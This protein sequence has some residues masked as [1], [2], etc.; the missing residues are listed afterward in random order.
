MKKTL[1][2]IVTLLLLLVS[3]G[4]SDSKKNS[5]VVFNT[6]LIVEG[7]TLNSLLATKSPDLDAISNFTEGLYKVTKDGKL[8]LGQAKK[9][10]VSENGLDWKV[11]LRDDIFWSNGDPVT[12][13]DFKFAWKTALDPKTG[14][15]Y[16]YMLYVI[17][18]GEKINDGK[19]SPDELGVEIIDDKNFIIHLESNTPYFDQLL[20]FDTYYPVN[21][22]FY[23]E[24]GEEYALEPK[25]LLSNGP[26]I[27]TEY[28]QGQK[29]TFVKNEKYW[30]AKNVALD[31]LVIKFIPNDASRLN[32]FKN[33]EIDLTELSS[34]Q[35]DEFKNDNRLHVVKLPVTSY[36]GLNFE[37]PILKN[38]H[39]RKAI[40]L[41][42]N[43]EKL[44]QA[45]SNGITSA[46][47]YTLTPRDAGIQGI[48]KDYIE[49]AIEAGLVLNKYNEAEAKKELELGLKE[50]GLSELPE[51]SVVSGDTSA[52]K[53]IAEY[54]QEQMRQVLGL[55]I[56]VELMTFKE[57][58]ARGVSG[59]Y[60]LILSAW[61]A[62]FL[63]PINFL[64]L[65]FSKSGN[66]TTRLKNEEYDRLINESRVA[67][68]KEERIKILRRLEQIVLE[69]S[70]IIPLSQRI[71]HVLINDKF[72]NVV[73]T[74]FGPTIVTSGIKL[75]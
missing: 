50:L 8:E 42:L 66:N 59:D 18:N 54:F 11:E 56:N 45:T 32:A 3:C 51:L 39:I 14:S 26:F 49:E 9:I 21:E 31:K 15:E 12:S 67:T 6:S 7:D 70:T 61:G 74:T 29:Q 65:L 63:D 22:K 60:Q 48:N 57:R 58:I 25:N 24:Q 72:T 17:K 10:E 4:K 43:Q 55:K 2:L 53:K 30:D 41:A 38:V 75:K 20:T 46:P 40:A 13:N 52:A 62:D 36:V 16:A 44:V 5:E 64:E 1:L 34:E 71:N 47:A 28:V 27:L 69:Q 33:G 19:L 35:Y 73:L 68:N 23:K 37:D